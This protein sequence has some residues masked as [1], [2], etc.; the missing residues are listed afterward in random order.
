MGYFIRE[1]EELLKRIIYIFALIT[2]FIYI[3]Y[4]LV[5]TIPTNLGIVNLLFGIFIFL[6]ELIEAIEFFAYYLNVLRMSKK[7]P[8]IPSVDNELAIDSTCLTAD[9]LADSINVS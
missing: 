3:I 9:S 5:F 2:T 1:K 8:T 4:R 7:S 6:I